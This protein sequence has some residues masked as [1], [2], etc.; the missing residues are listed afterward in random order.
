MTAG[1]ARP[2][3]REAGSLPPPPY[4][5]VANH[6]LSFDGPQHSHLSLLFPIPSTDFNQRT[7]VRV[8]VGEIPHCSVRVSGQACL[9]GLRGLTRIPSVR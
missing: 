9:Q 4:R 7:P 1:A 2:P 6:P 8:V 3:D 5:R